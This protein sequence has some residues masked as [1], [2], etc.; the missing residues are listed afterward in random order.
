MPGEREGIAVNTGPL[1]ALGA[2]G[3]LNLL[4]RIHEPVLAPEAVV[5]E[6]LR[7][8][9]K[10]DAPVAV[11]IPSAFEVCALLGPVP[12]LLAQALD[13]G[14]AAVIALALERGVGLVAID[15]Q[16][17]RMVARQLGLRVAGSIGIL[18]RAKALGLLG[19]VRPCIEAM[20]ANGIWLSDP[21]CERVLREA[22][23]PPLT[24]KG[25]R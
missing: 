25:P 10:R 2:C 23:E 16:R 15:E 24:R 13:P 3:H 19:A 7:G 5:S 21:L 14:E 9:E 6:L 4:A 22:G 1:I 8:G 18:L 11:E 20:R 17:G 12:V